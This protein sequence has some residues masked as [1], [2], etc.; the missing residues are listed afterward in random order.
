MKRG[1]FDLLKELFDS[2]DKNCDGYLSRGE[3]VAFSH[4]VFRI[5]R[6]GGS[7]SAFKVS[8]LNHD[9]KVSFEEFIQI[10]FD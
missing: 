1:E 4:E 3:F 9:N 8:D 7:N 2:Y 10:S 6:R 5:Y